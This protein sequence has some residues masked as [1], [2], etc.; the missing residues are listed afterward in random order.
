MY[1]NI[2]DR[3]I[4]EFIVPERI[5]RPFIRIIIDTPLSAGD[6]IQVATTING[7][8]VSIP[9]TYN[10][11]QAPADGFCVVGVLTLAFAEQPIPTSDSPIPTA[12]VQVAD[13]ASIQVVTQL[14]SP[15][16]IKHG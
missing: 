13:H 2:L 14:P 4:A 8:Q 6:N 15:V 1:L 10:V 16:I 9:I 3:D 5:E 12:D 11:D 7:E